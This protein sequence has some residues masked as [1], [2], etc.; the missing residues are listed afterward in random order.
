MKSFLLVPSRLCCAHTAMK[1]S[2]AVVFGVLEVV[3]QAAVHSRTSGIVGRVLGLPAGG[4][5]CEDP[6]FLLSGFVPPG[7]FLVVGISV[8]NGLGTS[9]GIMTPPPE[10]IEGLCEPLPEE[11]DNS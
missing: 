10:M 5:I 11:E 3:E 2:L 8:G 1:A 9:F 4:E 6:R 7:R